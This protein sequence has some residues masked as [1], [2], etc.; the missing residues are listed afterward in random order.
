LDQAILDVIH[1]PEKPNKPPL[2]ERYFDNCSEL[3]RQSEAIQQIFNLQSSIFNSG[4]PGLGA[5]RIRPA[6]QSDA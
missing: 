2:S 6:F 3:K 5:I 1:S 4:L